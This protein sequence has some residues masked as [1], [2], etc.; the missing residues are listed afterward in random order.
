ML[1]EELEDEGQEEFL[2]DLKK[3][4]S[5]G[6]H[7]LAL[8][9]DILD[10]S[11][12]E[13]GRVELE[14]AELDLTRLLEDS[15]ATLAERAQS[16]GLEFVID[17]D[18]DV[19]QRVLGD[20]TRLRQV[21]VNLV[22]NAVR[23]TQG[24]EIVVSARLAGPGSKIV[25]FDV[26]DTGIGID[27]DSLDRIFD[28]F[29]QA[30]GSTTRRFGGTGLGLA[31][32]RE[33]SH[34]MG[35]RCGVESVPGE[36]S[37]FWFTA[38]L[39]PLPET[40]KSEGAA[41]SLN[42]RT[43]LVLEPNAAA[44]RAIADRLAG[45]GIQF[46]VVDSPELAATEIRRTRKALSAPDYILFSTTADPEGGWS[47]AERLR[48]ESG[49]SS[50]LVAMAPIAGPGSQTHREWIDGVLAKPV[51]A[52]DLRLALRMGLDLLTPEVATVESSRR[53]RAQRLRVLVAED[54]LVNQE[55]AQGLL[56]ELGCD[57]DTAEDG[58]E[59]VEALRCST[60]DLVF[61]DC[62]MPRMDGYQAT[63]EIRKEGVTARNGERLPIVA[64]T[65]SAM[66]PDRDKCLQAGMDE[67]LAKPYRTEQLAAV[68][69][70]WGDAAGR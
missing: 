39:Q 52:E 18:R 54:N 43:A 69:D 64:L 1:A 27:P 16:K 6:K 45:F 46:R 63:A 21:I 2:P 4:N 57:V 42:G 3:I 61:M 5:A 25:R 28:A 65:A 26:R 12:I 32:V 35:G 51:R 34:R 38:E 31:I 40:P 66:G 24:G 49:P 20:S 67:H 68:L 22:G 19:P 23:F 10:L 15:C 70:R 36:G 44:G 37:D 50:R 47:L 60:Y 53:D 33:L 59:A 29:T 14:S 41:Q 9:N 55:V 58:L 30:D 17:V 56:E 11:K 62:M 48:A 13:A 8:I 7:L